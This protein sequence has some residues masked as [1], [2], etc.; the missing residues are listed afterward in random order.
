MALVRIVLSLP[1]NMAI[2]VITGPQ[3]HLRAVVCSAVGHAEPMLW[4]SL[5]HEPGIDDK[6]ELTELVR[7]S[8]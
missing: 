4:Q 3:Q 6:E 5:S 1:A 7:P 8:G 2:R